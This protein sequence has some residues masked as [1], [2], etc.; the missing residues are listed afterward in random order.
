LVPLAH[1]KTVLDAA[2][3]FASREAAINVDILRGVPST[4][5]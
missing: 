1:A 2:E 4:R 3:A 5:P